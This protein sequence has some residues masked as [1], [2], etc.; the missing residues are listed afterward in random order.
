MGGSKMSKKITSMEELLKKAKECE[1]LIK[2][3]KK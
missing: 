3:R 1:E 2:I